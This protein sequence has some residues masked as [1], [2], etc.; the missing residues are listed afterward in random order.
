MEAHEGKTPA[1]LPLP[2]LQSAL[3]AMGM[4]EGAKDKARRACRAPCQAAVLRGAGYF[5]DRRGQRT[6]DPQTPDGGGDDL[7]PRHR[8][9][10]P[11]AI[12]SD[13]IPP[14]EMAAWDAFAGWVPSL[15]A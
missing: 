6:R 14:S 8:R 11:D 13:Q 2:G 3:Y 10:A 15:A 4:I 1:P 5:R 7:D 12:M 9:C